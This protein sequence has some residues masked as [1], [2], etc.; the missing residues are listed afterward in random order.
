V[1]A[2]VFVVGLL[3]IMWP[4][5]LY[6]LA[7]APIFFLLA[8]SKFSTDI[9]GWESS[10]RIPRTF[11]FT[12]VK[13]LRDTTACVIAGLL[14]ICAAQ[15]LL[16]TVLWLSDEQSVRSLELFVVRQQKFLA[17]HMK[18]A[19]LII[20]I[21]VLLL[22]QAIFPY[23][24]IAH[25]KKVRTWASRLLIVLTI[26][27]SFSFFTQPTT[28]SLEQDWV[29]QRKSELSESLRRVRKARQ[30]LVTNAYLE[31]QVEAIP[32]EQRPQLHAYFVA[33]ANNGYDEKSIPWLIERVNKYPPDFNN[34]TN[35]DPD[36]PSDGGGGGAPDGG[37]NQTPDDDAVVEDAIN[38]VDKW[39]SAPESAPVSTPSIEDA[40][41]VEAE[42]NRVESLSYLSTTFVEQAVKNV[43]DAHLPAN[44]DP[45]VKS[46]VKTLQDAAVKSVLKAIPARV[47]SV[48]KAQAWV[49]KNLFAHNFQADWNWPAPTY[50]TYQKE[51]ASPPPIKNEPEAIAGKS[52]VY[53]PPFSS[54]TSGPFPSRNSGMPAAWFKRRME[55]LQCWIE[56]NRLR[57]ALD[58]RAAGPQLSLLQ[59][60]RIVQMLD[61]TETRIRL[62]ANRNSKDT[63]PLSYYSALALEGMQSELLTPGIQARAHAIYQKHNVQR[64][65]SP[66]TAHDL[67]QSGNCQKI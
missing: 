21:I 51:T 25:F 12:S 14:I 13:G 24:K 28:A 29:A 65:V 50:D 26:V 41:I 44:L 33:A 2:I 67:S 4:A 55:L 54:G 32:S 46:V 53:E 62:T 56:E 23:I 42:A 3:P 16:K 59:I 30:A 39:V 64:N 31:A 49:K 52:P 43:I 10:N 38:R 63:P 57:A 61:N 8:V 19:W 17:D 22:L 1:S 40:E 6:L 48:Q 37:T 35:Y 9:L 7:A 27:T 47:R 15:V 60:G 36:L 11:A 58:L 66:A 20:S 34:A 18:F 5:G 45:F